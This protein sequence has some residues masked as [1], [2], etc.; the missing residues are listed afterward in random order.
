MSFTRSTLTEII[1]RI[2]ADFKSAFGATYIALR[3]FI[4]IFARVIGGAV[5]LLYGYIDNV[6]DELFVLTASQEYLEKI[7]SEYGILRNASTASIGVITITGTAATVIPAGTELQSSSDNL[8]TTDTGVTIGIGGSITVGVTASIKGVVSNEAGGAVLTF[9]TP[10]AGVD[11]SATVDSDGLSGGT[12]E[13]NDEDYRSRILIRKRFAPHGGNAQDY[14]NWAKEVSGVTRA[15]VHELFMGR[16]TLAVF[17]MRDNDIDPFPNAAAVAAVRA[18]I[19]SHTDSRGV[20]VGAPVTADPGLVVMAPVK[21]EVNINIQ[22]HPNTSTVQAQ[23]T[24]EL[25]D[26][27]FRLGG[28]GQTIRVSQISEAISSAEDEEYHNILSPTNLDVV[29]AYNEVAVLGTATYYGY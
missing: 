26:L 3:S 7:G 9:V 11:T 8:Y 28:P 18:Y 24:A 2:S 27:F 12:D 19:I 16:G 1:D 21:R 22:I 13:E 23:V 15:W 4:Q 5:H 14:I 6:V 17:F 29:L 20:I 25:V 10:I